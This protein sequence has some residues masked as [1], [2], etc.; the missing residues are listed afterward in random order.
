MVRNVGGSKEPPQLTGGKDVEPHFYSCKKLS[1]AIDC[2]N[3]DGEHQV[4]P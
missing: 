3:L 1:S 2:M 4:T